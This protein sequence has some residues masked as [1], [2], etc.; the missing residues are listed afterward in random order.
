[1]TVGSV[2]YGKTNNPAIA[3]L[4]P[5]ALGRDKELFPPQATN[6]LNTHQDTCIFMDLHGYL[7]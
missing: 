7:I 4:R 3:F 6:S 5:I 2:A 1:M